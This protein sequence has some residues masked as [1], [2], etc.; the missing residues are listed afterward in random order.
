M[1][2]LGLFVLLTVC[3]FGYIWFLWDKVST[4][5]DIAEVV[6]DGVSKESVKVAGIVLTIRKVISKFSKFLWIPA[7]ILLFVNLIVSVLV[8]GFAMLILSFF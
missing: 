7:C 4:V 5:V 6:A 8:G 1:I 2:I 3:T